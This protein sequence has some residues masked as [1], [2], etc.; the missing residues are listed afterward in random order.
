[1]KVTLLLLSIIISAG[2][3]TNYPQKKDPEGKSS[4]KEYQDTVLQNQYSTIVMGRFVENDT[5]IF[6]KEYDKKDGK[7]CLNTV[8]Y[9]E[10]DKNSINYKN[11]AQPIFK[12]ER[13]F[14]QYDLDTWRRYRQEKQKPPLS[15]VNLLDLPTDWIPLHLYQNHYYIF[16]PC[17]VDMPFRR[18]LT[19]S[20]L[21]YDNMEFHFN[22]IQKLEK[23]SNSVY[24]IELEGW[25]GDSPT[26]PVQ[27]YIHI[28]D[29]QKKVAIW[30]SKKDNKSQYEL[31]IPVESAKEF[32][33]IVCYCP[34]HKFFE[35]NLFQFD[36]IDFNTLLKQRKL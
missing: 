4:F 11:I 2:G 24:Y 7:L 35:E 34:I 25:D 12:S 5:T 23:K 10:P 20:T 18:C 36:K 3:I 28:I 22:A 16:R 26:P 29:S 8:I 30:E 27:I 21:A 17:E 33:M 1:M 19:D 14:D 32:D 31:M 15:K 6:L 13:E 9:V